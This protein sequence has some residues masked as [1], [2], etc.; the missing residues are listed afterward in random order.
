[1]LW[2][3]SNQL[4]LN[5]KKCECFSINPTKINTSYHTD[6]LPLVKTKNIKYLG[7]RLTSDLSFSDY[8][9]QTCSKASRVLYML[10][11]SLKN[12]SSEVKRLAYFGVVRPLLE[13]AT[14]VWSPYKKK[15]IQKL[16]TIQRK[17][18][19]W[20]YHLKKRTEIS[21]LMKEKGWDTLSKRRSDNDLKSYLI[22]IANKFPFNLANTDPHSYNTRLGLTKIM[23]NTDAMKYFFSNRIVDILNLKQG[24]NN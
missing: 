12:S 15:H 3:A 14:T 17:A 22:I 5:V 13:Y 7:L 1:M 4:R 24:P 21:A 6:N 9:T 19:R 23:S 2:C 8:I 20:V 10:M 18:F 11:R 16:E